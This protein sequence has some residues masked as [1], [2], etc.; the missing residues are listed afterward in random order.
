MEALTNIIFTPSFFYSVLRV[1]TP[2]LFAAMGM[3]VA[4]TAGIPNIAL[5]GTMLIAAFVGRHTRKNG[6]FCGLCCG[7][8]FFAL[9]LA[10]VLISG[11]LDFSAVSSFKLV[12][13]I[14]SGC[15]GGFLSI[16]LNEKKTRH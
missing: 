9:Y 10:A 11:Q 3:V 7:L 14:L 6:L 15:L 2:I 12:C 1:T 4:N 13:F 8:T 16:L 5:E